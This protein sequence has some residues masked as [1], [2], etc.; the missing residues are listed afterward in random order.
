MYFRPLRVLLILGVIFGFG[1]GF[2]AVARHHGGQCHRWGDRDAYSQLAP[3][4]AAPQAPVQQQQAPAAQSAPVVVQAPVAQPAPVIVVVP[5]NTQAP[6]IVTAPNN[7]NV[8][9]AP[10]R[11]EA[12]AAQ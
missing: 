9:P 2:A 12:P 8:A 10:V 1:S 3:P 6:T 4:Y 11:G 7:N 5:P